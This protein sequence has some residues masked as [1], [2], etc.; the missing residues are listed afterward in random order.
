MG[1][2]QIMPKKHTENYAKQTKHY[3]SA[4]G[5]ILFCV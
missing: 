1:R 2:A 4:N 3:F 5:S